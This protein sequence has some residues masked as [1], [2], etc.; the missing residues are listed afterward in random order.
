MSRPLMIFLSLLSCL[1]LVPFLISAQ[2]KD[3]SYQA[4]R[5]AQGVKMIQ[6]A[7]KYQVWTQK[8]GQGKIKLLLLH[9]G[10]VNTHEYMENFPE[11]LNPAEVEVYFYD[12]LGS[13]HSDQPGD[14]TLWHIDRFVEEVEQVRQGLGLKDFYLLGHSW[15][16]ML[17][18]EYAAKYGQ[19]L[20]GLIVSNMGYRASSHNAYRRGLYSSIANSHE[21]RSL[22]EQKQ[23]GG[24]VPDSVIKQ[25][26]SK[27]FEEQH[28]LRLSQPP[29]PYDRNYQHINRKDQFRFALLN[30]M[31]QWD[32][33]NRLALVQMPT[34]L[35]GAKYDFIPTGD[36]YQMSKRMR[37]SRVY[38]CPEGSHFAMWDDSQ[39]YFEA[40]IRF[41]KDVEDKKFTKNNK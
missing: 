31:D 1:L 30:E 27:R 12:Q 36:Y 14:S 37:Q 11:R 20:K 24:N 17:A 29:E 18:L 6:V 25:V 26:I 3:S 13:Y 2:Q 8:V 28:V 22:L 41:F 34:L 7:G 5:N 39:H 23:Q 38:I 9:G 15:G 35:L 32:F 21:V 4:K 16:G 19:H 33:S 40:L 10:P